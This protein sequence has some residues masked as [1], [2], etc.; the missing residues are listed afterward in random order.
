MVELK[1][2]KDRIA[3]ERFR[4]ANSSFEL[5]MIL[6]DAASLLTTKH[7][8]NLRQGK[9]ADISMKLLQTF[10]SMKQHYFILERANHEDQ[11][12]YNKTRDLVVAEL[13]TLLHHLKDNVVQM[14]TTLSIAQ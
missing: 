4:D 14:D 12:S 9:D 6:M 13:G 3:A 5:R 10:R 1:Q 11:L 2:I 8:A 7:I